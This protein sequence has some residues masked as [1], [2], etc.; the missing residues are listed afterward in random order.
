M[1]NKEKLELIIQDLGNWMIG[2]DYDGNIE[3]AYAEMLD[4]CCEPVNLAG[5]TIYAS[6]MREIDPVMFR[7][8]VSDYCS[9]EYAEHEGRY[10]LKD[11][12][13]AAEQALEEY[14]AELE[15]EGEE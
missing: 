8:G 2:N 11:Q 3:Y 1:N 15:E 4:Q 13:E 9:E 6:Q 5:M 14:E 12:Y 7:C 10:Y